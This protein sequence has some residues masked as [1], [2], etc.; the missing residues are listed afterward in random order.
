MQ[1]RL[2]LQSHTSSLFWVQYSLMSDLTLKDVR[3]INT[4]VYKNICKSSLCLKIAFCQKV[5]M[6]LSY[7]LQTVNHVTEGNLQVTPLKK[8]PFWC[9]FPTVLLQIKRGGVLPG[10]YLGASFYCCYI[11]QYTITI[12]KEGCYLGVTLVLPSK[13]ATQNTKITPR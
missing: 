6:H 13:A 2:H 12:D 10:C 11:L 9:E 4:L 5:L 8:L 3:E 7:T 1:D